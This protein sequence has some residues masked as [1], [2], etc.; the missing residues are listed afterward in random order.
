MESARIRAP[1]GTARPAAGARSFDPGT[2]RRRERL[3]PL[4]ISLFLLTV[5][6]IS[7]IHQHFPALA[8]LHP[9]LLLAIATGIYA[10]MNP[11]L[12][13]A[14]RLLQYWPSRVVLSLLFL[15]G[16]SVPFGMSMGGSAMFILST[17][18]KVLIFAYLLIAVMKRPRDLRLFVWAYVISTGILVWLSL[19]VF[20]LQASGPGS[21]AR[22]NNLYSYDSNDV[23]LVLLVGL[24]LSLLTLQTSRTMGKIASVLVL[25]GIGA[26]I[27]RTGSRGAFLGALVVGIALLFVLRHVSVVKRVLFVV[28]SGLA[29]VVTAPPGY[30]EQMKTLTSPKED[31]NWD[32]NY[33]RRKVWGRGLGY[34]MSHPLTG[35]GIDNFGRAEGTTSS[36]AKSFV[37][38][39]GWRLKWSAAHNSFIQVGAELGI[40]G[41][42]LWS[43]LVFGLFVSPT[44]LR[45]RLPSHWARG[46]PDQRFT[47]YASVYL[48]ISV[49]AFI[50][51]AFFLSFAYQDIIY[52]LA[53]FV[54]GLFVSVDVLTRPGPLTRVRAGVPPRAPSARAPRRPDIPAWR[55]RLI[56][57]QGTRG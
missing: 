14:G 56:E 52:M 35:I 34:M 53:A 10:L 15:A 4:R 24:P 27:A 36:V 42:V 13:N 22:L 5:L 6:T 12:I 39:P 9:A 50:A 47:Y 23:G 2:S 45:K 44:R 43:V 29:L 37:D 49:I 40:P 16:L 26:T 17:Y 55:R 7:R 11:R 33:G 32:A 31:Y 41:L 57:R 18:S 48:P 38:K 54:T 25:A 21:F 51:T 19:F 30:W 46:D 20:Q 28:V 1:N 8:K 3:D